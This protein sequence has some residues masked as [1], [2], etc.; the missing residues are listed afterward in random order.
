MKKIGIITF[1]RADNYGAL[2]QVYALQT[3]IENNFEVSPE[4]IDYRSKNIEN[5][6]KI[7]DLSS[8][9]NLKQFIYRFINNFYFAQKHSLMNVFR[10]NKLI[11]SKSITQKNLYKIEKDYEKI[12]VGSDQV[13]NPKIS[14]DKSYF[15][16]FVKPYK[17]ASFSASFGV[18][19]FIFNEETQKL[20]QEFNEISVREFKGKEILLENNYKNNIEVN[21]DP[22]F[23]LDKSEWM[24]ISNSANHSKYILVY[25]IKKET[26]LKS[27]LSKL[28]KESDLKVIYISHS[29]INAIK[30][31]QSRNV[32]VEELIN[33][34]TN[35]SYVVTNSF[36]GFAFSIIFK[37]KVYIE[38]SKSSVANSR[39]EQLIE[40]F[41]LY[42]YENNINYDTIKYFDLV[43]KTEIDRIII[44]E[45]RKSHNYLNRIIN[46]S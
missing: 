20:I 19:D 11:L 41:E 27:I 34:I 31:K 45:R 40:T 33:L 42:K 12:I 3:Y 8:I 29:F 23:L 6:Y 44:N 15:L 21:L 35:A 10:K 32:K 2:L 28:T 7:I 14:R 18:T 36:H 37:K 25:Q 17:K 24:S 38:I 13:W 16:D 9:R 22:V 46:G 4:I 1:H 30:Y 26:N 5:K 43:D 39:I